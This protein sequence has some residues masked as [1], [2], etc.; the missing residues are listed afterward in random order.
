MRQQMDSRPSA[1]EREIPV[2]TD[3]SGV[4]QDMEAVLNKGRDMSFLDRLDS[5]SV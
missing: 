1:A 2:S 5:S 4:T 3:V